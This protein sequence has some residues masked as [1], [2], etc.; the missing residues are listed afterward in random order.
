MII[1]LASAVVDNVP[2]VWPPWGWK[3]SSSFGT[4]EKSADWS[5]WVIWLAPGCILHSTS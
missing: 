1:G 4:S 2:L 5:W 3:K